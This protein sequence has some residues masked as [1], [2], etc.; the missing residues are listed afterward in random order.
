MQAIPYDFRHNIPGNGA[1]AKVIK[2]IN[3]LSSL[4]GK[5]VIV[6]G[7]SYGTLNTLYALNQMT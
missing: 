3:M 7:H 2:A 6:I 4:T 5:K 1:S